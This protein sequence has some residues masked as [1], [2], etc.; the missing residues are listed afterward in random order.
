MVVLIVCVYVHAC[1]CVFGEEGVRREGRQILISPRAPKC[2]ETA[3]HGY[4]TS[5]SDSDVSVANILY[6][7]TYNRKEK[8]IESYTF[9]F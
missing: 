4:T 6:Y 7:Y 5:R 9:K 2:L 1:M 8:P 3:L